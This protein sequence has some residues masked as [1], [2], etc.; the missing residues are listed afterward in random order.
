MAKTF[1]V[2]VDGSKQGWKA[3]DMATVQAQASSADLIVAHIVP[4]ESMPE[5][6]ETWAEI[7]GM[8]R[9][10]MRARFHQKR[11]L[12]D[13]IVEEAQKRAK[14]AGI[15]SVRARVVEGNVARELV[16]L[17]ADVDA[18][19]IFLGSRGLS[20]LQGLL[21]GSVS[22]KVAHTAPCSCVIVR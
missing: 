6:L 17:A 13:H 22:H 1:V 16:E 9:D 14:A 10:E 2:A 3:L 19:M 4:F 15:T 20:D 5:A 7:E 21:L 12:G 11:A 8:T 18:D